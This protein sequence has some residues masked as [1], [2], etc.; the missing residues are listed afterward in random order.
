MD[1]GLKKKIVE[2]ISRKLDLPHYRIFLFGSRASGKASEKS[3]YDI[4]LD[5]TGRIP[6]GRLLEIEDELRD[7]RIMQKIDL[8]NF[9]NVSQEFKEVALHDI[10]VLYER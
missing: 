2:I 7:L 9:A 4:G 6:P 8:V 10:E 3:D 5:F 1:N